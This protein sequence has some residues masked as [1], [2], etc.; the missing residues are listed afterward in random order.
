MNYTNSSCTIFN[1]NVI[2][3]NVLIPPIVYHLNLNLKKYPKQIYHPVIDLKV[4]LLVKI[5]VNF[6]MQTIFSK[7]PILN[8]SQ[9]LSTPLTTINETFFMKNKR[10]TSQFFGTVTLT[11]QSGFYLLKFNKRNTENTRARC[12]MCLKLTVKTPERR[13]R[14]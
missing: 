7:R 5:V 1:Q 13:Q 2:L 12:E 11:T 8:V 10:A 9:L 14:P 6:E 4:K 3:Q